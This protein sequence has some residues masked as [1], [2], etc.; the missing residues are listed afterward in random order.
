MNLINPQFSFLRWEETEHSTGAVCLSFVPADRIFFMIKLPNFFSFNSMSIKV[1]AAYQSIS[2]T[3]ETSGGYLL[4]KTN[5]NLNSQANRLRLMLTNGMSTVNYYSQSF[6]VSVALP[7]STVV[8]YSH[9]ENAFDFIYPEN[10]ANQIR[11]PMYILNPSP[12]KTQEVYRTT[13]GQYKNI[14]SIQESQYDMRAV[15]NEPLHE[16]L[17]VALLHQ[18]LLI[19]GIGFST[20]EDY[21]IEWGDNITLEERKLIGKTKVKKQSYLVQQPNWI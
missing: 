7:Y 2:T 18:T 6:S 8:N 17:S 9:P 14:N 11:L 10:W 1:G 13:A 16:A 15:G 21:E 20:D 19:D 5:A 12:V 3:T 4:V